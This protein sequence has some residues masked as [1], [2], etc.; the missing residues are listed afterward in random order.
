[1]NEKQN[2]NET[3]VRPKGT[4]LAL[5]PRQ[6]RFLDLYLS[7]DSSS[8]GNCYRSALSAGYSH[9]TARNLTHNRPQWLSEK[10]GQMQKI[11]PELLLVK[12]TEIINS[13]HETTPMK[14]RAID[15]MM[16]HY[17]MFGPSNLTAIQLNI[18]SVLD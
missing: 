1:M 7:A 18:Q 10:L 11:E 13:K 3:G 9:E 16:K 17:Q 2:S 12:L 14:L 8:F 6:E 15:M 4:L 5:D